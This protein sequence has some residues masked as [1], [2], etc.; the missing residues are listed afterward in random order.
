MTGA[1]AQRAGW[2]ILIAALLVAP[3]AIHSGRWMEF[4]ELTLF[5]A[6][7]GQGW[8]ILGGYG[9]QYSF[10]HALFFGT[11]AYLQALLQYKLGWSPWVTMWFA[12]G[13]AVAV[14][15]FVG[16]LS[17]RYGLRGSYFAL[18]TLAF[19]EA[20]H[21][22]SRSLISVTEGGRGVQLALNQDPEKAIETFQF[23]F[24]GP[25]LSEAG[26]YYTI[27][28]C[29]LIG[30]AVTGWLNHSRFGAQLQAVR[31]DEDAAEALGI[32][33]FRV[34]M[35]AIC[36]SAAVTSLAGIYYVQK[37]L[38]VDPGIAYGPGKSVEALFAAIIGGLGTV[39]G[40]LLGSAFIHLVGEFAKETI[41]AMLGDRPGV[42]LIL[43]GI[44]LVL[45]LAY[46][47]RGLVGL[48]EVIWKR[49]SAK[50]EDGHA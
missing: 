23:T 46:M 45:I 33:A 22:L 32:N 28:F 42:D 41:G 2:A 7:L 48:A 34:K 44:I 14:G 30:F 31:E 21:V 29:L 6:L 37:F 11:A 26:Y 17:F 38:F 43:F 1:N 5:A 15:A 10:G 49:L 39:I 8:N 24:A 27:L 25:F 13:G 50:K 40:P 35:G 19:A 16:F 12:I 20:F 4:I 9:G 3:F 47:P 18:V 36:L